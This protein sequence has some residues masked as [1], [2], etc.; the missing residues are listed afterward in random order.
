MHLDYT[1][2]KMTDKFP[3]TAIT[4]TGVGVAHIYEEIQESYNLSWNMSNNLRT[5]TGMMT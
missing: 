2:R 3:K 4:N 1:S 5:T